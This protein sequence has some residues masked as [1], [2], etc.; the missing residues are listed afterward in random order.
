MSGFG[1]RGDGYKFANI[2]NGKINSTINGEKKQ[3]DFYEGRL[4]SIC[5]IDDDFEGNITPKV[6]LTMEDDKGERSKIKFTLEGWYAVGFF[7]RI[8]AVDLH[9]PFTLGVM[10]SEENA[11]I[12]FCWLKQSGKKIEGAKDV[13]KPQQVTIGTKKMSDFTEFLKFA[14]ECLNMLQRNLASPEEHPETQHE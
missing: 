8:M 6:E 2:A 1:N 12:S 11:K 7:A 3:F 14:D 10:G 9:K 4:L 5:T 13:P